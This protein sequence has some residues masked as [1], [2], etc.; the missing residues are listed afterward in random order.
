MSQSQ[1]TIH[2]TPKSKKHCL[3][4]QRVPQKLAGSATL[5]KKCVA[6]WTPKNWLAGLGLCTPTLRRD[7]LEVI[8]RVEHGNL[9]GCK[10]GV[11]FALLGSPA[12]LLEYW[13]SREQGALALR[14]MVEASA[15]G[16]GDMGVGFLFRCQHAQCYGEPDFVNLNLWK[17]L[18]GLMLGCSE[19]TYQDSR[20]WAEK[21]RPE[22]DLTQRCALSFV[23]PEESD[24]AR[25]DAEAVIKNPPGSSWGHWL[26]ETAW[27]LLYSLQDV[28]L[29]R[30]LSAT[31]DHWPKWA[32]WAVLQQTEAASLEVIAERLE[33]LKDLPAEQL[34][35]LYGALTSLAT[36]E[37]AEF[38]VP[39]LNERSPKAAKTL[40]SDYFSRFPELAL[41]VL[42]GK[43]KEAQELAKT[44]VRS[45]LER[46][47]RVQQEVQ[48]A[49]L[50]SLL[51]KLA[52]KDRHPAEKGEVPSLLAA[53]PWRSQTEPVK[54]QVVKEFRVLEFERRVDWRGRTKPRTY[55][56]DRPPAK[57]TPERVEA[58][59]RRLRGSKSMNIFEIDRVVDEAVLIFL[60]E[61]PSK[62]WSIYQD[63]LLPITARFGVKA[64]PGLIRL[65]KKRADLAA[66]ALS[67][68]VAPE[69]APFMAS[70][71]EK[72]KAAKYAKQWFEQY[73][74]AAVRGLIP[75]AIGPH[76]SGRTS[77]E[78]ALRRLPR[79]LVVEV[80][81]SLGDQVKGAVEEVLN[82]DP[83][84][85]YPKKLPTLPKFAAPELLPT[86]CTRSGATLP[87]EAV[88]EL[89]T[90][91]AF[92]PLD[93]PYPGVPSLL[94][95][96][97]PESLAEFSWELFLG[98]LR[99]GAETKQQWAFQ[100]LAHYGGDEGARQLTPLLRKWPGESA[101]QRAVLGLDILGEIGTDV[102]LMNLHGI[103]QKLRFKALQTRAR[104]KI[105]AIAAKRGL[106]T[107][108]LADR[109]VPDLGLDSMGSLQLD[110]GSR[111]FEV[112]LDEQLRPQLTSN[113]KALKSLPKPSKS[114]D[115]VLSSTAQK[116]WRALKKDCKQVARGQLLRLERA[117][118]FR[119]RWTPHDFRLFLVDQPLLYPLTRCL[120][121]GLYK[122][123][124]LQETF[125]VAED[126]TVARVN[127]EA[128]ELSGEVE[129]GAVHPLDLDE[130][131][132]MS[133]RQVWADYEL[134]QPFE[135]LERQSYALADGEGESGRISR[136]TGKVVPAMTLLTLEDRGWRRAENYESVVVCFEKDF[137]WA[138]AELNFEPGLYLGGLRDS[139]EQTIED[140]VL[141]SNQTHQETPWRE[142]EVV[143]FSEL[144]R[145][146]EVL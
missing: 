63:D 48:S 138:R 106:S 23:F 54:G 133:W 91:L 45:D 114:D 142:L 49:E 12:K 122:D 120:I 29:V 56:Y 66:H 84:S 86:V 92:T 2:W 21:S 5:W 100:S 88:T 144:V 35:S 89:L 69:V 20:N 143:L 9:D 99:S 26:P 94:Q 77:A 57:T 126:R 47:R 34:T 96:L 108:E 83:L 103:A 81:T 70:V 93:T 18:R 146:L 16:R 64:V 123:G 119:R 53:P 65:A 7:M 104:E 58:G 85:L 28:A 79:K 62:V 135:Q 68:I 125:R 72:K 13:V 128:F 52:P 19:P 74:D 60:A 140:V 1:D 43:G 17:K 132:L 71:L 11:A 8:Q 15:L 101:H 82:L 61:A 33:R 97:S 111:Q 30:E 117:M 75:V 139:G 109:L 107:D 51:A 113:G 76:G 6:K 124:E 118:T 3:P 121:W 27:L 73:P 78:S 36:K 55:F 112:Y 4:A 110:Y 116:R 44:L 31:F 39:R 129:V 95:E 40:V 46:A 80:A 145:D 136:H 25:E 59:L 115:E 102:A 37:V 131:Q 130:T 67:F 98:W 38:L 42:P 134:L 87:A 24:W 127:D 32:P 14:A 22:L 90:M 41:K 137:G 105:A 141:R 50:G 10:P